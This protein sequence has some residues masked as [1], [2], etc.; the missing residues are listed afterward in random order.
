M[1][2]LS[3]RQIIILGLMV[4]VVLYGLYSLVGVSRTKKATEEDV[5][6]K[7]TELKT[8]INTVTMA[9]GKESQTPVDTYI[10]SMAKAVW[11]N[12]PFL[13][14]KSFREWA[15]LKEP[16]KEE[17]AGA[18][19]IVFNYT[20]YIEAGKRKLAIINGAEYGIGEPLDVEGYVLKA[21]LPSKI[22]VENRVD[23]TN[24]DVPFQE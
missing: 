2:N 12:D 20:G 17:G 9:M 4:L 15:K 22:V 3:R 19:K 13:E 24:V 5:T 14:R 23:K 11:Q 21:I 16:G 18:K 6:Q 7:V 10:T 1:G 8:F